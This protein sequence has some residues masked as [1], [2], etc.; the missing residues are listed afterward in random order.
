MYGIVA[1]TRIED[2]IP[3][4]APIIIFDNIAWRCHVDIVRFDSAKDALLFAQGVCSVV[5]D[6]AAHFDRTPTEY[7][8]SHSGWHKLKD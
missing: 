6:Q 1:V 7:L 5:I 2:I 8:E 3:H 4:Y